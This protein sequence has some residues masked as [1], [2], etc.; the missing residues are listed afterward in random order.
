MHKLLIADDE[1]EIRNGLS[2]YI[3]W[4]EMGFEVVGHVENGLDVINFI[5]KHLVDVLLCDIRMPVMSGIDVARELSKQKSPVK[6]VLLSGFKEFE[7]AQQALEFGVRSYLLKPAKYTE[8]YSV[9]SRIKEDLDENP[10]DPSITLAPSED[11]S[12]KTEKNSDISSKAVQK[13]KKYI[14]DHYKD[15]TLENAAKIVYLNP[16]YLSKYFKTQTGENFSDYV[17]RIR[18]NKAVELL[19][20][21]KYKTYEISEMVGYSNAKNFTRTFRKHFGHSPREYRN[22]D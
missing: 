1:Y 18:M 8:I 13:I 17:T 9:F 16:Y 22:M 12:E 19:K 3:P 5:D 20:D 15:A 6:I 11:T 2:H 7:Y 4:N 21:V 10:P 14:Q